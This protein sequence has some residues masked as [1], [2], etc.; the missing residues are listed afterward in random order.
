[1]SDIVDEDDNRLIKSA[2]SRCLQIDWQED[3]WRAFINS[4]A[5]LRVHLPEPVSPWVVDDAPMPDTATS[6]FFEFRVTNS[7]EHP[8][9]RTW[10][11]IT[12]FYKG[13][14]HIVQKGPKTAE[15]VPC[16]PARSIISSTVP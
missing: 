16:S 11:E 6:Y 9:N 2:W 13:S 4:Y 12:G 3:L 1:M 14:K 10:H 15:K 8:D 5:P 7:W